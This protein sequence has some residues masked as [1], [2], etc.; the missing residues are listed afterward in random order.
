MLP[1]S[2]INGIGEFWELE[3]PPF[4]EM[5]GSQSHEDCEQ[6]FMEIHCPINGRF[7]VRLPFKENRKLGESKQLALRQFRRLNLTPQYKAF[8]DEYK[9]LG[10]I[11]VG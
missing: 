1:H 5:C 11:P 9:A 3:D 7:C 6:H 4:S 8:M 10:H 2:R